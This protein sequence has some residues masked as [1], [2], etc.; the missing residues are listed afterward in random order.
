MYDPAPHAVRAIRQ[1][2]GPVDPLGQHAPPPVRFAPAA[3]RDPRGKVAEDA[4]T[5]KRRKQRPS[6][7]LKE[8]L[9]GPRTVRGAEIVRISE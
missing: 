8:R 4:G 5:G 6:N 7:R 9:P 1:E 2:G 3:D